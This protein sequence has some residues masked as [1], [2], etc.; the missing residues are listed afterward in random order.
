VQGVESRVQ[1]VESKVQGVESKVQ[2]S[3]FFGAEEFRFGGLA[4]Y[5]TSLHSTP[6]DARV[7]VIAGG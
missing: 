4:L 6:L 3:E 7:G 2:G 1:S 5:F